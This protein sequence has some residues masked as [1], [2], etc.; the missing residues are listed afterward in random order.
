M[1]NDVWQWGGAFVAANGGQIISADRKTCLMNDP[2]TVEAIDYYFGLQFRDKAAP[3]PGSL[4]PAQ[5][6]AGAQFQAQSVGMA[7]LGPWFRPTMAQTTPTFDWGIVLS[8]S[9]PHTHKPSSFTY[10]DQ[11]SGS[12]TTSHPNEA[13]QLI[14]W[15]GSPEFHTAWLNAYGASSLDAVTSVVNNPAWMNYNGHSGKVFLEEAKYGTPPPINFAN[16]GR[17]QDVWNQEL[18]LVQLGQESAAAA[19]AKIVPKVNAILAGA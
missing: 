16:G 11:W 6:W 12:S 18:G 2:K 7:I 9:S 1:T 19:V 14:K 3:P 4:P 13:W 10:V 8:P 17:V 5:N 15:L